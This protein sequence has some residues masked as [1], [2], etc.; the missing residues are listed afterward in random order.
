[1][2][3]TVSQLYH[4][5]VKSLPGFASDSLSFTPEA[6]VNDRR[7]LL[8]NKDSSKML[9]QRGHPQLALLK[10]SYVDS[11]DALAPEA[12]AIEAPS[13]A[14][15]VLPM[16]RPAEGPSYEVKLWSDIV[17]VAGVDPA[18]DEFFSDYLQEPI[19]LTTNAPGFTR[20]REKETGPF[21]VGMADGYPLLICSEESLADLNGR[22][23]EPVTMQ[24]FR[25]N[26][27]V[28][29]GSAFGEDDLTDFAIGAS[30]FT[31]AK[32]CD[33]CVLINVDPLTAATSKEPFATLASYR[34]IEGKA[35]FGI[36]TTYQ[37]SGTI[38]KG[39]PVLAAP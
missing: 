7:Y 28:S 26:V 17:Q 13:G 33:R 19:S 38:K 23:A 36:L 18:V 1:M 22:L 35:R 15:V 32:L 31:K 24:R 6:V 9:T 25:P 27:V 37:G 10:L 5:P 16:A 2:A 14:R 29:G 39:Q 11:G 4:Y 3:M 8:V 21:A 30:Q 20:I 34:M 12:L